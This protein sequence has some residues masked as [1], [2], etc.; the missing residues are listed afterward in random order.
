ME[1][2]SPAIQAVQEQTANSKPLE[3]PT[4]L[5][6]KWLTEQPIWIKQWPLAEDVTGF[7]TAGTRATRC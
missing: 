1:K 3:V 6:L 2:R 7:G 5:P 4:A